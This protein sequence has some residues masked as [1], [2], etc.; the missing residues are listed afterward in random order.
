MNDD[1]FFTIWFTVC[2]VLSVTW[3]AFL[4]WVLYRLV[5]WVTAQ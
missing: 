5:M 1:R 2:A 4:A 3:I